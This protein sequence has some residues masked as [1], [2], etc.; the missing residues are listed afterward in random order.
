MC[1]VGS[2]RQSKNVCCSTGVVAQR[3]RDN[4]LW[5]ANLSSSQGVASSKDVHVCIRLG[6]LCIEERHFGSASKHRFKVISERSIRHVCGNKLVNVR[7]FIQHHVGYLFDYVS[8]LL[9]ILNLGK[10]ICRRLMQGHALLGRLFKL[11]THI[12]SEIGSKI[13][14]QFALLNQFASNV[15]CVESTGNQEVTKNVCGCLVPH[16]PQLVFSVIAKQA[17]LLRRVKLADL[18]KRH[19]PRVINI[20]L[21]CLSRTFR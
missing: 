21:R 9:L 2:R 12:Q 18:P 13:R 15:E 3:F 7:C 8:D 5:S 20:L 6:K 10:V 17:W 4:Q 14:V 1:G 19:I 16:H 11:L